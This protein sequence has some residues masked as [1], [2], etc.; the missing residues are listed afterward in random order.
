MSTRYFRIDKGYLEFSPLLNFLK[1]S[2]C[3]K[4]VW[5]NI[6]NK[7]F[8]V[9]YAI[10]HFYILSFL[11]LPD[12]YSST[13]DAP[14]QDEIPLVGSYKTLT[15]HPTEEGYPRKVLSVN[16]YHGGEMISQSEKYE[17]IN[18]YT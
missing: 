2:L 5:G 10:I 14:N 6:F 7:C 13:M 8:T 16:W 9:P 12:P 18:T 4:E 3:Y 17:I 11:C 15:C 1:I